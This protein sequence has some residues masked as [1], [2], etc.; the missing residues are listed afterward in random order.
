MGS[1]REDA[2]AYEPPQTHNIA[3]L[4]SV[5]V[6]IQLLNGEGKDKDGEVFNYKY[7]ELNDKQYRVPGSVLGGLKAVLQKMPNLQHFSVIKQ[8]EGMNTRYT[9]IPATEF[10]EEKVQ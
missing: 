1:I 6:D 3:E 2:K 5:P 10:K 9:V 8:G 4:D 7:I